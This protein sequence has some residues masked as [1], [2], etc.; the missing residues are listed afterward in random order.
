[1]ARVELGDA[2]GDFDRY[3]RIAANGEIVTIAEFE[4]AHLSEL[5]KGTEPE[6]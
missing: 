1:M 2:A 4:V 6:S 3:A 5:L